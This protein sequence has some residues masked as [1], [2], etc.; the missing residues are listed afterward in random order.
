VNVIKALVVILGVLVLGY[1]LWPVD[2]LVINSQHKYNENRM[3]YVGGCFQ[4][5]I[6]YATARCEDERY[7]NEGECYGVV[8]GT[9]VEPEDDKL[10]IVSLLRARFGISP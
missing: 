3:I 9:C 10:K 6:G 1:F 8:I 5:C 2:Y 7:C 4:S